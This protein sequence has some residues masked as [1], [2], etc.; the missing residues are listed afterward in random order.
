[1]RYLPAQLDEIRARLDIVGWIAQSVPLKKS[2]RN[3]SACC[4]FHAEK[5]PSFNVNPER[6]TFKCFG[7]GVGGDIF[8]FVM[9][10]ENIGFSEAVQACA[11]AAHVE[12]PS[13]ARGRSPAEDAAETVRIRRLLATNALAADFFSQ[14]LRRLPARHPVLA[15]LEKRHIPLSMTERF[16]LGYAPDGWQGLVTVLEKKR[17]NLAEAETLGLVRNKS[18][19]FYDFFRNRLVFPI[20]AAKGQVIGFGAREIAEGAN[21]GPKYL[22]SPESPVYH[23][24]QELYGLFHSQTLILQE[25][26]VFIV[27]GYMDALRAI[28]AGFPAVAPLGTALTDRQ[29]TRLKRSGAIVHLLFDGDAAGFRALLRS[30]EL[31]VGLGVIPRVVILPKGEDPDSFIIRH[32]RDALAALADKAPSALDF[33]L[34]WLRGNPLSEEHQT[35]TIAVFRKI[36]NPIEKIRYLERIASFFGIAVED[37]TRGFPKSEDRRRNVS[38]QE[39]DKGYRLEFQAESQAKSQSGSKTERAAPDTGPLWE[40]RLLQG[41]LALEFLSEELHTMLTSLA[42]ADEK[43]LPFSPRGYHLFCRIAAAY[44]KDDRPPRLSELLGETTDSRF[45]SWLG[46]TLSDSPSAMP[47]SPQEIEGLVKKITLLHL[48]N[49]LRSLTLFI[50]KAERQK[51]IGQMAALIEEKMKLLDHLKTCERQTLG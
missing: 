11:A 3:Y 38:R 40:K 8:T 30:I 15:Y 41:L 19:R 28:D 37:L 36:E 43:T 23:K 22:N 45:S 42:Q 14:S 29:V 6:Q 33:L 47:A 7:C 34:D 1:M 20:H 26:R 10:R 16:A 21:A 27:E 24:G 48:K 49:K 2:G 35:Q 25:R 4:P 9:K 18:G 51:N 39:A 5:T 46:E 31:A 17:V 50:E 44:R 12:L 13:P 32:G